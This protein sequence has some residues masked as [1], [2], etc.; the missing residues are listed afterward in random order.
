MIILMYM[1][2][3]KRKEYLPGVIEFFMKNLINAM[4]KLI[5]PIMEGESHYFQIIDRYLASLASQFVQLIKI[6]KLVLRK[7]S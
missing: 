2:A 7:N 4:D 6:K 3:H 5:S 1:I